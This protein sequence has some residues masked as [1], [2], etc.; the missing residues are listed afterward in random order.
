MIP[1]K[2]NTSTESGFDKRLAELEERMDKLD[3]LIATLGTKA[4]MDKGFAAVRGD[5]AEVRGDIARAEKSLG[6][7][8]DNTRLALKGGFNLDHAK[9]GDE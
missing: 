8:I 4:D 7:R 9:E 1:A 6:A 2:L 3:R 5:I